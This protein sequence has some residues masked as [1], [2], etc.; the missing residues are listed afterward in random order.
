MDL[1]G[2]DVGGTTVK[3]VRVSTDGSVQATHTAQTPSTAPLLTA[4]VV[5]V[6]WALRSAETAAT[7]VVSPGVLD[8]GTVR[9]AANL[10]WR[11]EPVRDRLADAL[12]MPVVLGR[13]VAAAALA[14]T[15]RFTEPDVLFVALGTG[16]A[17]AHVVGTAVR[18]GAT[19]RAGEIG[20]IP[21]HP[22]GEPCNCGQ[23]GCLEV[24]A[25]AA[26]LSRRYTE[27]CGIAR[28]AAEI[29]ARR[30]ADPQAA[31]VWDDAVDALALA[32]ATETL[33]VDPGSIMIGGGLA[34]AGPALLEPL[35]R[36][37]IDRL[38]WRPPAPLL[39]AA[40]GAAAGS[41]GAARL[42]HHSLQRERSDR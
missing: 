21:V 32:L 42:A 4:A 8:G 17:A 31:A 22:D 29:V 24:Y 37:L 3:G 26:G 27:R 16:I 19:G 2:I 10:P 12:G 36:R 1:I 30:A 35:Q 15:A 33:S 28:D 40:L 13:D 11:E 18:G 41:I 14:E 5:E 23:R 39:A 25:S 38:A 9:Y 20:H 34:Q 6:A 7:G